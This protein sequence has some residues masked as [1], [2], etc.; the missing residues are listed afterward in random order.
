MFTCFPQGVKLPRSSAGIK[1]EKIK[2]SWIMVWNKAAIDKPPVLHTDVPLEL[3]DVFINQFYSTRHQSQVIQV[4]LL[5][6]GRSSN[7]TWKQV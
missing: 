3:G 7:Y 5:V 6:M 2:T 1:K 4:W